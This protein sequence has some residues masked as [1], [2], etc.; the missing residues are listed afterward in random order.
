MTAKGFVFVC[1]E[2]A[3]RSQMAQA[4][5]ARHAP[6]VGSRSA[7]TRPAAEVNP[8]VVEAMM[9]VGID[10]SKNRPRTLSSDMLSGSVLVNMGCVDEDACPAMLHDAVEWDIP[11]PKGRP[12]EQV[13]E[14]RDYVESKVRELVSGMEG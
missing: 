1:V 3:G 8:V 14:I 9:E 4:F 13:R 12:L 5:L 6:G 7:G 2:N 11:D 10:L